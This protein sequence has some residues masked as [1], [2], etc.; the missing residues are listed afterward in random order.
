[1]FI[2]WGLKDL[3]TD[4]GTVGYLHC[5]RCNMDGNWQLQK[6]TS[7]FTLFFIPVIPYH[8][9]YFVYCPVCHWI[10]EIPKEE[11]KRILEE[12]KGSVR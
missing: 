12:R 4:M 7:W 8:R 3:D 9:K 2:I 5:N 1:M 6:R 10:T 11:A